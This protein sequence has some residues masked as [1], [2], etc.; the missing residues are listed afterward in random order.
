MYFESI[1]WSS[2]VL[3]WRGIYWWVSLAI[4]LRGRIIAFIEFGTAERA[5]VA[6]L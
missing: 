3:G 1:Y 2:I 6:A 4:G 5:G